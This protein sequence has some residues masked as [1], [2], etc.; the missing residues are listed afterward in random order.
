MPVYHPDV[1]VWEVK[2]KTSGEHVGLWYFDPYARQGKR[3][4]AWMNAYR[5]QER[6]DGEITTHRLQ[7]LQLRQGQARRAGADQLGGRDHALPRVRPRAARAGLRRELPDPLRH[8]GGARLR[9]VPLAAARALA[10]DAGGA[11]PL[12]AAPPDRRAHPR[13]RWWRRSSKAST[14]NQGFA[15][16]E[17]LSSRAHRHEAPPGRREGDRPGGLRARHAEGAGDA[18]GD[19]D[20]APHAAVRPRLRRA[21]ATR[22]ATTATC[23][24]TR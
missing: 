19:R 11:Q 3:S 14:F 20:A 5:R 18:E 1:R 12:R 2:D 6:F 23:G 7:Q 15:T 22:P 10:G 16:V 21:T 4:G 24:R 13:R 17:Y 8:R 9:G